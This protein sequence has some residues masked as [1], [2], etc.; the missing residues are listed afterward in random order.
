V[1]ALEIRPQLS[2]WARALTSEN[3]TAGSNAQPPPCKGAESL[4]L[5]PRRMLLL[6][7][8]REHQAPFVTEQTCPVHLL[9]SGPVTPMGMLQ[10]AEPVSALQ[11]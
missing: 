7:W 4:H 6:H 3:G 1:I 9:V 11:G 2:G 8:P 5:A 10:W